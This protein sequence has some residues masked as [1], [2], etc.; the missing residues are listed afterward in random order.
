MASRPFTCIQCD[1][2]LTADDEQSSVVCDG[3]G[4]AYHAYGCAHCGDAYVAVGEGGQRCPWC[5]QP[6][7]YSADRLCR[8]ADVRGPIDDAVSAVAPSVGLAWGA[9]DLAPVVVDAGPNRQAGYLTVLALVT[10]VAGV[11]LTI[12][13]YQELSAQYAG[14]RLHAIGLIET[15]GP[16]VVLVSMLLALA[17]LVERVGDLPR[18]ATE[19]SRDRRDGG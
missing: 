6:S 16:T 19:A 13:E 14:L 18:R 1:D 12:I 7:R 2:T 9:V 11:W 3:C 8:F 17:N 10:F 5:E 4:N 15:L